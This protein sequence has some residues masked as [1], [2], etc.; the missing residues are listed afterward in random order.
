MRKDARVSLHSCSAAGGDPGNE[1]NIVYFTVDCKS[2]FE[3]KYSKPE[4]KSRNV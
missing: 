1:A 3:V 2:T 4:V